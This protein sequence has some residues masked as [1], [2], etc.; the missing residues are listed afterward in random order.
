[1]DPRMCAKTETAAELT[2]PVTLATPQVGSLTPVSIGSAYHQG[3]RSP[4]TSIRSAG[5]PISGQSISRPATGRGSF[6]TAP[7][8]TLQAATLPEGSR[9]V[10]TRQVSSRVVDVAAFEQHSVREHVRYVE[11]P[12]YEEVIKEVK[13]RETRNVERRVPKI[14]VEVVDKVVEVPEVRWV[15]KEVE[16]PYVQTIMKH[17]PRIEIVDRQIDI[18]KHVPIIELQQVEKIVEVPGEVIEVPKSVRVEQRRVVDVNHDR[19]VPVLVAQSVVPTITDAEEAVTVDVCDLEPVPIPVDVHVA[20]PVHLE[21]IDG[22]VTTA[23]KICNPPAGQ[24]NSILRSL[25]AHLSVERLSKLPYRGGADGNVEFYKGDVHY[26]VMDT[27]IPVEGFTPEVTPATSLGGDSPS[28]TDVRQVEASS[29][30]G[31]IKSRKYRGC[32]SPEIRVTKYVTRTGNSANSVSR[33]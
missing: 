16:V 3:C 4:T 8:A 15:D 28:S 1:M 9:E 25:N 22:P 21:L 31:H 6:M 5:A 29:A 19:K 7:S 14:E 20:K 11:V 32:C 13:K 2:R 10:D 24:Y 33:S 30:S 23:Y 18:V 17:K 26:D 12:V 27:G